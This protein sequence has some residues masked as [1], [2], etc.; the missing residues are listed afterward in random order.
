MMLVNLIKIHAIIPIIVAERS[1]AIVLANNTCIPCSDKYS[2]LLGANTPIA[3]IWIPTEA[4]F[5]KPHKIL[6]AI[7]LL[8][9]EYI[10]PGFEN[11][12]HDK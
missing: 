12:I 9:F 6:V 4:M 1:D 3:A 5:A 11:G 2:P 8:F 10:A 7:K